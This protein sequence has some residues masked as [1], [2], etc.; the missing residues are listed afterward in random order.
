MVLNDLNHALLI[1]SIKNAVLNGKKRDYFCMILNGKKHMIA[2]YPT[3][4]M[5]K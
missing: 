2:N 4:F 3:I 1:N 5:P